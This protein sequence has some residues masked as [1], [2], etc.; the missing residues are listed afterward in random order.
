VSE[1]ESELPEAHQHQGPHASNDADDVVVV[2]GGGGGVGVVV[3]VI[4]AA[5]AVVDIVGSGSSD[6][7]NFSQTN[8]FNLISWQDNGALSHPLC[9]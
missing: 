4:A 7:H 1:R 6:G 8:V 2:G 3:V 9:S 5:A